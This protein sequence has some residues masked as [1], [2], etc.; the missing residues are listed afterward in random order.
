V[1]L[2]SK[3]GIAAVVA[4]SL[5]LTACGSSKSS[6]GNNSTT[7]KKAQAPTNLND[8]SPL[9]YDQVATGG[10][11][12]WPIDSYPPNFNI[13]EIDGNDINISNI[14]L[15]TLPTVW[16][17][18]ATGA[19]ILNTDVVDKADQT[20]TS[21]QTITYH[22]NNKAVWSDG[23]PI[24]YKDF[25]GLWTALN[26]KNKAFKPASTN[27]YEQIASVSKGA[28]DQDVTVVFANPYPDW[29]SLFDQLMPASLDA[30]PTSFNTA[31]ANGPTLSGGPF[32]VTAMDKTAKTITVTH[33]PKWW[34]KAPKL[35]KIQYIVL[36]QS[37]QAKALQSNQID[38]VDIGSDVATYAT[39]KATP[40]VT[41]HK[42]GGPNWRHIDLGSSGPMADE[43]VRQA[44]VLSM[45]RVGDAKTL[46]GPL[47][48]P[49]KVLDSH[50]WMNN[51]GQYKS[52]CGDFCNQ[53]IAKADALLTGEGYTKGSDGYY[54]KAGKVL[55]LTFIIPDGVKT[56][57]DEAALQ[58]K[59][60]Q[61]AGIKVTIKSVASDPFFPQ[62]VLVGKFDL[63]IFSWIGTQ[64]PI[65]SAQ[66]IYTS[67]GD[68]NYA[69]IGSPALDALYKQAV[70]E[71][72]TTKATNLTYQ[73][74]QM[75]WSEG[76][77]VPL[78]QRPDLV[79]TKSTLVNF[80][81]IGFADRVY[82]DIG[83]KK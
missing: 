22:I 25:A 56:S 49:A 76:H 37:A 16:H 53:D 68:Q 10:T 43:K 48:W 3:V 19:P 31:W 39:V 32:M 24:T 71:L 40:G 72:D 63:T 29:K 44:V 26:G 34:G 80:G 11:L 70:S 27:G 45:D 28:T 66:S 52:T 36:D 62:Y 35:D 7:G 14:M 18:D 13:N 61:T 79:A 12:R 5:A 54:S 30:T 38:F 2:L 82:E 42:A 21:P 64:F 17:F 81:S 8:V 74:D 55:N 51:Q 15:G 83:F 4:A 77:S 57:A 41:I 73:I 50:I 33:N 69:K 65:S 23:S 59:A 78:Y 20:S 75:I 46:L 67:N 1:R 60:L 9:A 58:Q 47:D 6:G